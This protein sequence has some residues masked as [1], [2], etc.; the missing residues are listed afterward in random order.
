MTVQAPL[1]TFAAALSPRF[2]LAELGVLGGSDSRLAQNLD[3]RT[4]ARLERWYSN[5]RRLRFGE[6]F[7]DALPVL[8]AWLALVEPEVDD[9]ASEAGLTVGDLNFVAGL[10]TGALLAT[11]FGA[12][13]EWRPTQG[14][15][16]ALRLVARVEPDAEALCSTQLAATRRALLAGYEALRATAPDIDAVVRVLHRAVFERTPTARLDYGPRG[17]ARVHFLAGLAAACS[18]VA[19]G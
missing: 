6:K 15:R 13:G 2:S 19:A 7:A 3:P 11:R 8:D 1:A 10:A 18:L 12:H 16:R 4:I 17:W 14:L 5:P 9:E